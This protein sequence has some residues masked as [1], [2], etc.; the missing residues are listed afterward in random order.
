[1]TAVFD[2]GWDQVAEKSCLLQNLLDLHESNYPRPHSSPA[3]RLPQHQ[4]PP[5]AEASPPGDGEQPA[6][7]GGAGQGQLHHCP[8]SADEV[9]VLSR[10]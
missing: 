9:T 7:G 10:F 4:R 1:M 2:C 6:E 3:S 8:R 5:L